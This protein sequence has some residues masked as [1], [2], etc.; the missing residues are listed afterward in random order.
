MLL[1]LGYETLIARAWRMACGIFRPDCVVVAIPSSD[2]DTPLNGELKRINATVCLSVCDERDVLGRFHWAAHTFRWKPESILV[3]WT[4]DDPFKDAR[5]VRRV[6]DGERLPVELGC[7]AFTLAM[8]DAAHEKI[9][10]GS[11]DANTAS[12]AY[13]YAMKREHITNALFNAPPP[14]PPSGQTLTVDTQA[15]FDA[16]VARLARDRT[17]GFGS[18]WQAERCAV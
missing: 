9:L 13:E 2:K 3:R 7:E 5:C 8:L 6:I 11:Y 12:L 15:D 16:A 10:L 1:K 14:P 17:Q 18:P 4:P